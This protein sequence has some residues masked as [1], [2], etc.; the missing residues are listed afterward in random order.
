[1]ER[2]RTVKYEIELDENKIERIEREA[3]IQGYKY[4][5]QVLQEGLVMKKDGV[6]Y[7]INYLEYHL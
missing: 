2:E 7:P 4:A 5:I 1:M 3:F 6:K